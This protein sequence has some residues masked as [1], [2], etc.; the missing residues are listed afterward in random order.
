MDAWE[1][2]FLVIFVFTVVTGP[3]AL[4]ALAADWIEHD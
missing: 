3:L 2:A 1:T 4:L